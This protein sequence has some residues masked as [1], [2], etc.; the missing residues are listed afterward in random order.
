METV[1]RP[2]ETQDSEAAPPAGVSRLLIALLI[3]PLL[4]IIAVLL[5]AIL[6]EVDISGPIGLSGPI[7]QVAPVLLNWQAP[8]FALTDLEGEAVRLHDLRGQTVFLNFWQ[9]TCAPCARELPAFQ[10][11]IEAQGPD[12]D[13]TLLA[14]NIGEN[15]DQIAQFLDRIGVSGIPVA[16]DLDLAVSRAYGIQNMPTTFVIDSL[17]MVRAM[18]LGEIKLE[19][20]VDYVETVRKG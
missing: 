1:Q 12:S 10:A 15:A 8:P 17:G 16:L 20:M 13:V 6:D 4:G 18:H 7:E 3:V 2:L 5:A 9:T 19:A 14:V 11:F